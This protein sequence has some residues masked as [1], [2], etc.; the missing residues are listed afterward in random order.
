MIDLSKLNM[1][2]FKAYRKSM[3]AKHAIS[4]QCIYVAY[5]PK[6]IKEL[7]K[8]NVRINKEFSRRLKEEK[9]LSDSSEDV[10]VPI[11]C[12]KGKKCKKTKKLV[13]EC[14]C[15]YCSERK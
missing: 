8:E 1:E 9:K 6:K 5:D 15:Y 3:I 7:E 4:L 12:T 13:N 14:N 2:R 11:I 10:L